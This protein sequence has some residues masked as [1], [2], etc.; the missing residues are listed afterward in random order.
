[1]PYAVTHDGRT[2][3]FP[4]PLAKAGDTVKLDLTT[5][6]DAYS[7]HTNGEDG[8]MTVATCRVV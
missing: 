8:G 5:G 3:R 1:M 7:Q 6:T 2:I 4:D